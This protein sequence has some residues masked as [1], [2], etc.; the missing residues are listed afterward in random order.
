MDTKI[1]HI[2]GYT[3]HTVGPDP[4]AF[5]QEVEET[6]VVLS[7][8]IKSS[9]GQPTNTERTIVHPNTLLNSGNQPSVRV[10]LDTITDIGRISLLYRLERNRKDPTTPPIKPNSTLDRWIDCEDRQTLV[11]ITLNLA[12]RDHHDLA[13]SGHHTQCKILRDISRDVFRTYCDLHYNPMR[14]EAPWDSVWLA[15]SSNTS[16]AILG[17]TVLENPPAFM[18]GRYTWICLSQTPAT[19][20]TNLN[21]ACLAAN[22]SNGPTR[23]VLLLTDTQTN[24]TTITQYN[25]NGN[26]KV[27]IVLEIPPQT[28]PLETPTNSLEELDPDY[29]LPPKPKLYNPTNLIMV[30]VENQGLPGFSIL[31]LRTLLETYRTIKIHTP[32]WKRTEVVTDIQT[33]TPT[34]SRNHPLLRPSQSWYRPECNMHPKHPRDTEAPRLNTGDTLDSHLTILGVTPKGLYKNIGR[35]HEN[36]TFI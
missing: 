31:H 11:N 8:L 9:L 29:G 4:S 33:D 19:Q 32:T 3:P 10:T 23:I 25:N 13:S 30:L 1:A 14:S 5:K 20:T 15:A 34:G 28:V 17:A 36:N 21:N 26:T 6:R 2:T 7:N 12:L 27:F 18:S 35:H 22:T 24:R 16:E